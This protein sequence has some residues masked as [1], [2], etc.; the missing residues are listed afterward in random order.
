[1]IYNEVSDGKC[2]LHC[3]KDN[4][5]DDYVAI[6][7]NEDNQEFWKEIRG[8]RNEQNFMLFEEIV[9][10]NTTRY[11]RVLNG[12]YGADEVLEKDFLFWKK[13]E[14]KEVNKIVQFKD[15]TFYSFDFYAIDAGSVVFENV[16]VKG[17]LGILY[18]D[19][20]LIILRESQKINKLSIKNQKETAL[21]LE[22]SQLKECVF[23]NVFF[24]EIQISNSTFQE[25]AFKDVEITK[26]FFKESY[27][28]YIKQFINFRILDKEKFQYEFVDVK[29]SYSK[30]YFR[31]FKHLFN[32][33][34]D[35]VHESEM[36]ANEMNTYLQET[37]TNFTKGYNYNFKYFPDL[38]VL[39]FGK[40]SSNFTKCW[41]LPLMWII[42]LSLGFYYTSYE[43]MDLDKFV[44]FL[45]PFNTQ[46]PLEN[47]K[48]MGYTTWFLHK[49]LSSLFLYQLIVTLKRKMKT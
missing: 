35:Y 23:E 8:I 36:Y 25:I 4:W 27:F 9:F 13:G 32:E 26:G 2:I 18:S 3:S 5:Q 20:N 16:E 28:K 12:M 44:Q 43:A 1:M 17:E 24:K 46:Y 10:P 40:I 48:N 6:H 11:H 15:C 38:I 47:V 31:F 14:R 22:N 29:K 49:V 39:G 41:I 34:K 37:W 21:Y 33:K 19:I 42:I 7:K 30:E 45:N